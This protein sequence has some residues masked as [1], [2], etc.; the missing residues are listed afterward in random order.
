MANP[1]GKGGFRKGQS[2]NPRGRKPDAELADA[3]AAAR[4]HGD[5]AMKALVRIATKGKSE[6]AVVAAA[7]AILNRG[8]GMPTQSTEIS[9]SLHLSHDDALSELE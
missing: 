6:A 7:T 1:T 8:Y 4:L 3:K 9:G 2:G 5:D